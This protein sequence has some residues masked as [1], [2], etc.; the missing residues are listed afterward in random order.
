MRINSFFFST[1]LSLVHL[2]VYFHYH[3]HNFSVFFLFNCLNKFKPDG[4]SN[5]TTTNNNTHDASQNMIILQ[6]TL[7]VL[8]LY[9]YAVLILLH[10]F[11]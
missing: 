11:Y 2:F 10:L 5:D 4:R 7:Y 9:G 6:R 8:P 3:Q 1:V